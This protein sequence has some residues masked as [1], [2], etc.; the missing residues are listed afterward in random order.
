[1]EEVD[2][3]LGPIS[4]MTK[5]TRMPKATAMRSLP[6]LRYNSTFPTIP[7]PAYPITPFYAGAATCLHSHA[8]DHSI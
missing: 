4:S 8:H 1:M 6:Q 2:Y 3:N 5:I 7:R